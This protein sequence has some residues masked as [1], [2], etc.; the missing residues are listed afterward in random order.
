MDLVRLGLE[1]GKTALE[2]LHIIT[3]L[4]ETVGQGGAC[5]KHGSWSYHNR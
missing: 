1:R 4:I 3:N 2:C 5:E